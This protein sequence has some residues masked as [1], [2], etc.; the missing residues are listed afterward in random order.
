MVKLHMGVWAG[1]AAGGVMVLL[2][3]LPIFGWMFSRSK[4]AKKAAELEEES[5]AEKGDIVYAAPVPAPAP[6][7]ASTPTRPVNAI[8]QKPS[9]HVYS[10][11]NGLRSQSSAQSM[12][13]SYQSQASTIAQ[14]SPLRNSTSSPSYSQPMWVKPSP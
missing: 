9:A 12:S 13:P 7:P 1:I 3:I 4:K 8:L 2:V 14:Q 10:Q 6:V 5:A 11:E